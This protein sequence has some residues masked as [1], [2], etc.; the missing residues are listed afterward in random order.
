MTNDASHVDPAGAPDWDA[1]A[2]FLAG[3]SPAEEASRVE[4][5][6]EG[7]PDDRAL[8]ERLNVAITREPPE[9]LDVEAA[10][11]RL[12]TDRIPAGYFVRHN[13]LCSAQA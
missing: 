2:R 3:D 11:K 5:W 12:G 8:V 6:L 4:Q 7:H 10:L 1:I 13:F 9:G